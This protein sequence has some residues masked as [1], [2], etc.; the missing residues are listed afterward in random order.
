MLHTK[1][2]F[3]STIVAVTQIRIHL[4]DTFPFS[5]HLLKRT[6]ICYNVKGFISYYLYL[7]FLKKSKGLRVCSQWK[8]QL[9]YPARLQAL[10]SN[11]YK[12]II[13]IQHNRVKKTNWPEATSWLLILQAWP[14]I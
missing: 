8:V 9:A 7:S 11:T 2:R 5:F 12:Q 10:Q 3:L 4:P 13:Q 6:E 1:E 14:R